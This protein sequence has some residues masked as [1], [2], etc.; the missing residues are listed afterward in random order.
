MRVGDGVSTHARTHGPLQSGDALLTLR[1]ALAVLYR[2][3]RPLQGG[4][5]VSL[6][7]T[8]SKDARVER[9]GARVKAP[10]QSGRDVVEWSGGGR[11]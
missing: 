10:L 5:A 11:E 3:A 6:L 7:G 4:P 9:T 2:R 8:V 1:R